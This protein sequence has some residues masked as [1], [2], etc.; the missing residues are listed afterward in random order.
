MATKTLTFSVNAEVERKFRRVARAAQGSKKGYLGRAL[1][2]AMER[3]TKEMEEA[4]TVAAAM[5][6]LE[7]G[8]DLG[9][10]KYGHRDEL[11]ER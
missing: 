4:D 11:H 8:V 9:G 6:L 10:M 5:A 7:K 2:D 3:W 1:T